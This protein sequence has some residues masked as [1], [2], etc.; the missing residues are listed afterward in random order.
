VQDGSLIPR[1]AEARDERP[2]LHRP[3]IARAGK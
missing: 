1:T 2:V 3:M